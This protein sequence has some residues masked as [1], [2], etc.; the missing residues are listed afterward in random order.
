MKLTLG[1]EN[2]RMTELILD[3]GP[4]ITVCKFS[5][6]N[7][8]LVDHILDRCKISIAAAVCNE[9]LVA[10]D[11]YSDAR[12]AQERIE[13]GQIK[14]LHPPVVRRL[15]ALLVPYGLGSGER[16]S[17]LLTE[18]P[19]LQG[20]T[21]VIDD[22]LAYLVSNRLGRKKRFLLD[23]IIDLVESQQLGVKLAVE[24]TEAIRSRY[25]SAF[26]EHT[27]LLLQR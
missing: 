6:D 17:I 11:R 7:L 16:D 23:V 13:R 12:A 14:F 22:H 2:A 19:D 18:H 25:P 27:M 1:E 21:L 9:V 10:G 4:L 8:L 3:A 5:V 26:I 20:A 15:E 24:M